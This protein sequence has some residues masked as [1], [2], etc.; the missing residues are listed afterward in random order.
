MS[1]QRVALIAVGL[2]GL[3]LSAA[4]QSGATYAARLTWVPI[5]GAQRADV[6]G[7]GSATASLTGTRLSIAGSFE[8]L[9]AP[10][11]VARVHQGVAKGAR[12]PALADLDV[13]TD[14]GGTISGMVDLTPDQIE[15]LAQGRLYV[16][17]HSEKGVEPDGSNLWGWL[18]R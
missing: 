13:T 10:A 8:G 6:T 9:A 14:T 18:L 16:Q 15:S 1:G 4:A 3:G 2:L 12:G 17:V 5:S 7:S 11:T